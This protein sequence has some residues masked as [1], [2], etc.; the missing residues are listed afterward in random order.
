MCFRSAARHYCFQESFRTIK[1]KSQELSIR[2]PLGVISS[3]LYLRCVI[4]KARGMAPQTFQRSIKLQFQQISGSAG[5]AARLPAMANIR[6]R[7]YAKFWQRQS[8]VT[9]AASGTRSELRRSY[10]RSGLS[11]T[12]CKKR[13]SCSIFTKSKRVPSFSRGTRPRARRSPHWP[14]RTD[15][16]QVW[17]TIALFVRREKLMCFPIGFALLPHMQGWL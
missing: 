6:N 2:L 4:R 12:E 17:S 13:G 10:F 7:C 1:R 5:A 9:G 8:F 3:A 11:P 16:A 14:S 15:L